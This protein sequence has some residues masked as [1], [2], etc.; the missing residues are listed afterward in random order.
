[1]LKQNYIDVEILSNNCLK[2][3]M[4]FKWKILLGANHLDGVSV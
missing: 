3:V 4:S 2:L 1:M